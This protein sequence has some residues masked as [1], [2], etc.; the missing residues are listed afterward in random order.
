M[1][2]PTVTKNVLREDAEITE[3]EKV[4]APPGAIMVAPKF[5]ISDDDVVATSNQDRAFTADEQ[6]I[7]FL[8]ILQPLSPAV[9][10]DGDGAISG[11]RPG[12]FLNS[13][14]EQLYDGK[15]GITI[16]PITH[17][18]NFTEWKPKRGGFV[19]NWGET[20]S[21][22]AECDKSQWDEYRPQTRSGNEIILAHLHYVY[23]INADGSYNSCVFSFA[24]T[25]IKKARRW[26]TMMSN[27]KINTAN[28][29]KPAAHS[30]YVYKAVTELERNDQGSWYSPRIAPLVIDNKW[31]SVRDLILGKDIWEGAKA[32]RQSLLEGT[33]HAAAP[34]YGE[35]ATNDDE[36][37]F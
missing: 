23:V 34:D 21:W 14:T 31:Q 5:E 3:V 11:A 22:Q 19:K 7:P 36:V 8:K 16:V 26:A 15:V 4:S 29:P 30:Y 25:L 10:E 12:M 1:K 24:G 13:A 28:G 32:F 6:T 17:E 20:F 18:R 2:K 9:Q 33:I 35:E 37:P 27:A